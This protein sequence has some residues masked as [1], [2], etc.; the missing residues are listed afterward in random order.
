VTPSTLPETSSRLTLETRITPTL[1]L[2]EYFVLVLELEI[3]RGD[4]QDDDAYEPRSDWMAGLS[5]TSVRPS[6][7]PIIVTFG[8]GVFEVDDPSFSNSARRDGVGSSNGDS[9][10]TAE[11]FCDRGVEPK[12]CDEALLDTL[13]EAALCS[14]WILFNVATR[15]FLIGSNLGKE[16]FKTS[17]VLSKCSISST[18][19]CGVTKNIF[20]FLS[21]AISDN[22]PEEEENL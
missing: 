16:L 17:S 22:E 9:N 21:R 14:S 7:E 19:S 2:E 10:E 5:S 12:D 13:D 1:S 4:G 8:M 15:D 11:E 3:E 6:L 18:T 20:C